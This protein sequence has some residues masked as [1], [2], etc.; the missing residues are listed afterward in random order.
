LDDPIDRGNIEA[1][2]C[3]IGTQKG[4]V[5][6]IRKLKE[7]A[8]SA[9]LLLFALKVRES[10]GCFGWGYMEIKDGDVDKVE[11][12]GVVFDRLTT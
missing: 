9:F 7:R 3:D 11:E 6:G 5:R 4:P 2:R 10:G 8:R 12:F 1:S